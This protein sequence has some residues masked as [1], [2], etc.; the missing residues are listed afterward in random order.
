MSWNEF[1]SVILQQLEA[2]YIAKQLGSISVTVTDVILTTAEP[3][4]SPTPVTYVESC[5]CTMNDHVAGKRW[6]GNSSD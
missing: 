6:C 3:G 5:S 1:V 4:P 2:I